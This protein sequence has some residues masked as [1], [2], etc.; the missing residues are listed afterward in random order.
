MALAPVSMTRR[1]DCHSRCCVTASVQKNW[2]VNQNKRT[3]TQRTASLRPRPEI[4]FSK[5]WAAPDG[6]PSISIEYDVCFGCW[7]AQMVGLRSIERRRAELTAILNRFLRR[8]SK[9]RGKATK[10][11]AREM[12]PSCSLLGSQR[13]TFSLCVARPRLVEP[14]PICF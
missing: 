6:E 11:T 7:K 13:G 10:A 4:E 12:V 3:K 5:A 14:R 8:N 9:Q 1:Q 2:I